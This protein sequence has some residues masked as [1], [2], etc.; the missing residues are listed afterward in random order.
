MTRLNFPCPDWG[1]FIMAALES[2]FMNLMHLDLTLNIPV[3]VIGEWYLSLVMPE[4]MASYKYE[5]RKQA[6][7]QH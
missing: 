3:A 2:S 6:R 4:V 1:L 7:N 5:Q